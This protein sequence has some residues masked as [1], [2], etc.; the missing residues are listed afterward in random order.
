MAEAP[1]VTPLLEPGVVAVETHDMGGPRPAVAPEEWACVASAVEKRRRE[2]AFGRACSRAALVGLGQ[3]RPGPIL[4]GPHRA[5]VWPQGIVGSITHI[6]GYCAAAVASKSDFK[7][8]GIDAAANRPLPPSVER[9]VATADELGDLPGGVAWPT[10]LFS[11]KEAVFKA[12]FPMTGRRLG[13]DEARVRLDPVAGV[14]RAE[15]GPV[16]RP[17][18]GPVELEGRFALTPDMVLTAVCLRSPY[19]HEEM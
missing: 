12:W 13:F 9:V 2:F 1:S 15:L 5:P 10:V 6:E 18:G 3:R 14:F 8:I 4:V 16:D 17:P 11:A 7:A 19:L